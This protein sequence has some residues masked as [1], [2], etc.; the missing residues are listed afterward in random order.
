M[1]ILD[2]LLES[3]RRN[4]WMDPNADKPY[5]TLPSIEGSSETS[6]YVIIYLGH[7]HGIPDRD[8]KYVLDIEKSDEWQRRSQYVPKLVS[9]AIE[10]VARGEE[11]PEKKLLAKIRQCQTYIR[12]NLD[13]VDYIP[14]KNIIVI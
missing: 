3:V 8:I 4:C 10:A 7:L 11:V 13:R 12:N 1:S 9:D 14:L 2:L 5:R 6:V